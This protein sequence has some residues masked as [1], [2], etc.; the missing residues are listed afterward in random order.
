MAY[1][2]DCILLQNHVEIQGF[3]A[4]KMTWELYIF[5]SQKCCSRGINIQGSKLIG[6]LRIWFGIDRKRGFFLNPCIGYWG[7]NFWKGDWN[8]ATL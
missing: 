8:A 5:V 4:R 1:T 3:F 7:L 2:P 6:S